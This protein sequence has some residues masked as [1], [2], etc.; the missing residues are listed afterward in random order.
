VSAGSN[1]VELRYNVGRADDSVGIKIEL[2][3]FPN[4][5]CDGVVSKNG[6]VADAGETRTSSNG[7]AIWSWVIPGN[8]SAGRW[9]FDVTCSGGRRIHHAH[10]S[11]L[12][13]AG[14]GESSRGLWI[15]G[16]LRR[17]EVL[18]KKKKGGNGGGGS[19]LY[20]I[21]QCTWWVA[22][23]RPDL[24]FFPRRSGDAL[25]WAKSAAAHGFPVGSV[26]AVGAVAVFQPNQ[27]G[28][29]RFGHVALVIAVLGREVK[30][31]EANFKSK[32]GHDVR[33]V[34]ASGLDFIYRKGNPAPSLQAGLTS[35]S[36]NATVHGTITV[37]ATS[38]APGIRFAAFSYANPAVRASGQWQ[39]LG[40]DETPADGFS[41]SWD[42]TST[43]NQGGLGGSSVVVRASVLG[44][45]GTPTGAYSDVRVNVANSRS[46]GGVTY[47]PYYVVGACD[48]G[49]CTLHERSGPGY[50]SYPTIGERHDGEEVDVV[51]Q[52]YGENFRSEFGGASDVWDRLTSGGWVSDYFVDTPERGV[53]S[54]PLPV[55]G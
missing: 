26:P 4:E 7:G 21:G 12:A 14:I 52:A 16:T 45:D 31:S 1:G 44:E 53:L 17:G 23:H 41:A 10:T 51:C 35:P 38:N 18:Q 40:D 34:P 5:L 28:A 33:T 3:G 54:P 24:P 2:G 29:G 27:Y 13:D 32:G 46:S 39:S 42:T 19:S 50:S 25:N 49:E 43:P 48:E 22:I 55:C 20:A 9:R 6:R 36:D 11:F 37:T 8:V 15:P 30:I 47:F